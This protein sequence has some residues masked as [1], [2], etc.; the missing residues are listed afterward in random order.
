MT[1]I[2]ENDVMDMIAQATNAGVLSEV[3][4]AFIE[5]YSAG[6]KISQACFCALYEWD[7]LPLERL[8]LQK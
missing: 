8:Y 2:E 7:A 1:D 5:Y 4:N 6:D 3:I